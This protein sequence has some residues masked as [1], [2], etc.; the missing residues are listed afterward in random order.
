[1]CPL[2]RFPQI[3]SGAADD[4]ILL[5]GKVLIEN[6]PER[7]DFRLRLVVD[8][9]K[10]INGKAGLQLCLS[11]EAVE[12]NLRVGIALKLNNDTHAVAVRLIA[13]VGDSF[14]ALFVHLIGNIFDQLALVDLIG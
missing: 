14:Q 11:K 4:Q 7:Q 10:H 3:I 8:E 13:K 9:C 12:H 2:F 6:M 5:E 1:M